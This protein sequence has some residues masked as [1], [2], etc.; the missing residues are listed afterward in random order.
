MLDPLI[1]ALI[2]I[3]NTVFGIYI[4]LIMLRFLLQLLGTSFRGEPILR[5]LLKVTDPPLHLLY[6]VIPGWKNIDIAAIFL[7]LLLKMLELGLTTW[8]LGQENLSLI[9]LLILA[10]A[11]LLSLVIYI[12]IFA[13]IFEVILN[14]LTP[15]GSYNPLSNLLYLITDPIL[16]PVR[17]KLPPISGLDFSPMLVIFSL[18]LIDILVVGMLRHMAS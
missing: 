3:I 17:R 14:L 8:L 10:T 18:Y 9:A 4:L 11:N 15:P 6:N 12:F 1:A 16:K 13:I 7:M 5:L 2:F